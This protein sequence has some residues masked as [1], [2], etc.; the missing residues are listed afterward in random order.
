MIQVLVVGKGTFYQSDDCL[1]KWD[2]FDNQVDWC[3]M[4]FGQLP[5]EMQ[6]RIEAKGFFQKAERR[7]RQ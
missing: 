3:F 1:C 4:H 2:K 6:K 7:L 5:K